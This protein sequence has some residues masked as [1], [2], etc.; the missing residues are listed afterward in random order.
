MDNGEATNNPLDNEK[1]R[2]AKE[3]KEKDHR[4]VKLIR[5]NVA[6]GQIKVAERCGYR[7]IRR[8]FNQYVTG[9]LLSVDWVSE[10]RGDYP[11]F[12]ILKRMSAIRVQ[13]QS[14]PNFDGGR[15]CRYIANILGNTN[16]TR[17]YKAAKCKKNGIVDIMIQRYESG[18]I[19]LENLVRISSLPENEQ[20]LKAHVLNNNAEGHWFDYLKRSLI[21]ISDTCSE[22]ES[23][24]TR[25]GLSEIHDRD[26]EAA[27]MEAIIDSVSARLD[28]AKSV[29]HRYVTKEN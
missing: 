18:K 5:N 20:T 10:V 28:D 14:D 12:R 11:E 22:Y 21:T 26:E 3:T 6:W 1:L 29:L 2:R 4:I 19:D 9:D 16:C 15:L 25:N 17:I 24:V 8:L 7:R 13:A 27:E 23:F